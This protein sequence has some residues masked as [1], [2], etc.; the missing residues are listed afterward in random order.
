MTSFDT[1]TNEERMKDIHDKIIVWIK[2]FFKDKKGPAVIGISGGKDSTI[3]AAL[4]T[5]ALG[6]ERVV[7]VMMPN[8]IQKDISDSKKVIEVLGIK[9]LTVNIEDAYNAIYN[10]VF[11]AI[12]PEDTSFLSPVFTTNTPA[13]LR[14]TTLYG[15]AAQLGGFVCNTCNKSEDY[16]GYSTKYGDAA[17]DFSLLNRLTKTEVVALGDYMKLP[18]E[19][20]HKTP[21]DGMC[22]KSDEANMG[23]TYEALDTFILTGLPPKAEEVF[24]KIVTMH[25]NPNTKYKLIEMPSAL[26][27]FIPDAFDRVAEC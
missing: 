15:I 5:E 26:E 19:L 7:G 17:G 12:K 25:H 22:G 20:V 8:G 6:P 11:D 9:G 24:R 21:S 27:E 14:M 13:R 23:F 2:N 3:C 10:Q 1:F 16:V 18:T 4:L